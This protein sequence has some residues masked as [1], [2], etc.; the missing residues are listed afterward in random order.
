MGLAAHESSRVAPIADSSTVTTTDARPTTAGEVIVRLEQPGDDGASEVFEIRKGEI[1]GLAG[2]EGHGQLL[3]LE[4]VYRASARRSGAVRAPRR[5]AHHAVSVTGD[6]AYVS[7]DRGVRGIFPLW[8]VATNISFSSLG[9]LTAGG[10]V[11]RRVEAALVHEWYS[12]LGIKGQSTD[13]ITSLSGG[14]QQK[15]LMARAMAV[16]S[17]LLLLEDPTR[18]VDQAT[19]SEVYEL[20]RGQA[21]EG[22]TIVWYSTENEELRNCDRVFVFRVG[23]IV[24]TITGAEATEDAVIAL[25]FG[26]QDVAPI[27][28]EGA[29]R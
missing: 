8:D 24:A 18:G 3:A 13:P 23:K 6:S 22:Q 10:L 9:K 15:A 19:K 4:A 5:T 7:G 12:R 11:K 28:L 14:T 17:D 16:G 29:V 25:S 21:A 27:D 2:L 26:G 1:I 20:L